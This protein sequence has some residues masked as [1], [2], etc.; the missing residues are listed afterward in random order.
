MLQLFCQDLSHG[1]LHRFRLQYFSIITKSKEPARK[2][3]FSIAAHEGHF[4]TLWGIFL[5]YKAMMFFLAVQISCYLQVHND[6]HFRP[7]AIFGLC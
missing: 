1:L 3:I 7:G 5:R 2:I 4:N 6:A